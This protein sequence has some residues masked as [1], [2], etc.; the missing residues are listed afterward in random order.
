MTEMK[1][2]PYWQ[3]LTIYAPVVQ[4]RTDNAAVVQHGDSARTAAAQRGFIV[5]SCILT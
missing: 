4:Q 2:L 5:E 1:A 3:F